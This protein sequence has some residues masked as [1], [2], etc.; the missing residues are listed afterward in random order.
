MKITGIRDFRDNIARLID[1]DESVLITKQ[2]K[3]AAV[4]Y[5]LRNPARIPLE[6]R[7]TLYVAM[8]GKIARQLDVRNVSEEEMERDFVEFRMLRRR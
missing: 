1:S 2:G 8:A 5:P 3:P 4:M 6:V 7:R